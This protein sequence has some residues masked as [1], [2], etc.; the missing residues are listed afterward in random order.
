ML[1]WQARIT[2]TRQFVIGHQIMPHARDARKFRSYLGLFMIFQVPH[3]PAPRHAKPG[4]RSH[5][6][7]L[8]G[9]DKCRITVLAPCRVAARMVSKTMQF[10]LRKRFANSEPFWQ[11]FFRWHRGVEC[12]NLT[13]IICHEDFQRLRKASWMNLCFSSQ[14]FT[15]SSV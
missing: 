13:V 11:A 3:A 7:R 6:W 1:L 12:W 2:S 14:G 10:D 5:R 9:M 4:V 8:E 15:V